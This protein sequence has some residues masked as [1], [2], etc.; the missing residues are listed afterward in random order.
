VE[1]VLAGGLGGTEGVGLDEGSGLVVLV[2]L[3]GQESDT[4]VLAGD[5]T[6]SLFQNY[7]YRLL[8][9][10]VG[11]FVIWWSYLVGNTAL[12]L[13]K[14]AKCTSPVSPQIENVPCGCTLPSG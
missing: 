3:L 6:D 11:A 1:N 9:V 14:L 7:Q 10:L 8:R 13:P 5:D 4:A 2:G 12:V